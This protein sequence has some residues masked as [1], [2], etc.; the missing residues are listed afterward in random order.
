MKEIL[1]DIAHTFFIYD[2]GISGEM[3]DLLEEYPNRKILVT[4]ADSEKMK[5]K[6]MT[7][8]PYGV[9][10]LENN[11]SKSEPEYFL[12]LLK[13]YKLE[14]NDVIYFDHKQKCVDSAKG[15]GIVSYYYDSDKRDLNELKLFLDKNLI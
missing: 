15:I 14:P 2:Q 11:P 6:G 8:L 5:K 7:D 13:C 3:Y 1:V 4:N 12:E 10:T 9:F